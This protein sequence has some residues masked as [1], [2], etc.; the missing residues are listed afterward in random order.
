MVVGVLSK[1][2]ALAWA[3]ILT[4][5]TLGLSA[6]RSASKATQD[7]DADSNLEITFNGAAASNYYYRGTTLSAHRPSVAAWVNLQ[8]GWFYL[9]GEA[10]SVKLPTN[11]L[12]EIVLSGGIRPKVGPFDL[13]LA[14]IYFLY[15]RERPNGVTTETDYWEANGK[16]SHKLTTTTTLAAELAYAPNYSNSGAWAT[17]AAGKIRIDLPNTSLPNGVNWYLSGDLGHTWFGTVAPAFSGFALPNYTHWRAGVAF[18]YS[19]FTLDL[20]YHDTNLAR[21]DCYV[22]TGDLS[23]TLGGRTNSISN[24][25][26]LRSNWCGAAFI[27]TL[28]F[29]IKTSAG[30]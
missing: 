15:P 7:Q 20:S 30:K 12:A 28:S 4:S 5:A 11:P 8:N 2:L 18:S 6:D 19:M 17:Y 1:P 14:L 23:A 22:F 29:E 13:D 26:G 10:Y 25:Q 9:T 27:A 24:P 16:V 3:L 21:E